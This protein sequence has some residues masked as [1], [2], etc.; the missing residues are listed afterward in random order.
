MKKLI[1]LMILFSVLFGSSI[2]FAN[3]DD[4]DDKA[5]SNPGTIIDTI[6]GNSLQKLETEVDKGSKS[7]IGTIRRVGLTVFMIMLVIAA[8]GF[9]TGGRNP[10]SLAE[11]KGK[12]LWMFAGLGVAFGAELIVGAFFALTG[13]DPTGGYE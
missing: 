2:A 11:N 1:V 4:D 9:M 7:A 8:Y 5:N 13:L 3:G 6:E 12:I 10:Q